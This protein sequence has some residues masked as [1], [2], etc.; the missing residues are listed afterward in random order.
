MRLESLQVTPYSLPFAD[1]YVTARGKLRE[2]ELVL[3]RLRGEGLEGWGET[4]SLSL[5]GGIGVTE[6]AREIEQVCW[7]ALNGLSFEP[8]RIWSALAR[9]R[10]RGASAQALAALDIA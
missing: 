1:P 3:V 8:S 7:P 6:I 10:T 2:R 5:R 9:C 4:A